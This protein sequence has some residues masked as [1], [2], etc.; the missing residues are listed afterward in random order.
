MLKN[1]AIGINYQRI[2]H[3]LRAPKQQKRGGGF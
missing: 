1:N 3:T 2:S